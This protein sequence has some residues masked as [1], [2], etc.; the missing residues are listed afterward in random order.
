[1]VYFYDSTL[2]A[3]KKKSY[4]SVPF[5]LFAGFLTL[6]MFCFHLAPLIGFW[7]PFIIDYLVF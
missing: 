4:A 6:G 5:F 7:G 1:M 3:M 2:F